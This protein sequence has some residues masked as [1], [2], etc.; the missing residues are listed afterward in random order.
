MEQDRDEV[1]ARNGNGYERSRHYWKRYLAGEI[2]AEELKE[3]L[4]QDDGAEGLTDIFGGRVD[5]T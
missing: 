2:T 5:G 1:G 3:Y 4:G